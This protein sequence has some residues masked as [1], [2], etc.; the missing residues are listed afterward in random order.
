MTMLSMLKQK[1]NTPVFSGFMYTTIGSSLSKI[2]LVAATFYCTNMLT[3]QEFGGFSFIRNTLNTILVMCALNYTGLCVKFAAESQHKENATHRLT[4][5]FGFSIFLCL[6]GGGT[7]F[8]LPNTVLLS[9]CGDVSLVPYFRV[10]GFLLPVFMLQPV[11]EGAYLGLKKF[12]MIGLL[13]VSSSLFFFLAIAV[14]IHLNGYNGAIVGML[15]YYLVYAL[16]YVIILL[17][18]GNVSS[19]F[20]WDLALLKN[21][22]PIIWNMILPMFLLSFVEA[23]VN[24]WAQVVLTR[25]E[26]LTAIASMTA[27]LQLRN[28]TA[29]IPNYFNN[30]YTSYAASYSAEKKYTTYFSNYEKVMLL[31]LV[32]SLA[33]IG[34]YT[35]FDTFILGLYGKEYTVDT[36]PFFISNLSVPLM[37]LCSFLKANMTIL[38]HQKWML[39]VS[40]IASLLFILTLYLCIGFG[41]RGVESFFWG[42][43]VQYLVTF[44]FC[45]IVFRIDKKHFL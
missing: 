37:V 19:L 31:F 23:P 29:L 36:T 6:L 40:I 39:L 38:E 16:I 9:L 10:V 1:I 42:Y 21:E 5:L 41:I 11:M 4:V 17:Y 32:V 20:S 34:F 8:V 44:I 2:I 27:I 22:L 7:L 26:S 30:A 12:K 14:G 45:F 24:W 33:I 3:K 13:Q 28:L 43:F 18:T 15:S 25:N 35:C